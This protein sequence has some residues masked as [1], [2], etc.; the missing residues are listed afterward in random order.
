MLPVGVVMATIRYFLEPW[1]REEIR[2]RAVAV[3]RSGPAGTSGAV[4]LHYIQYAAL[5]LATYK[6]SAPAG[7]SGGNPAEAALAFSETGI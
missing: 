4:L 7:Q 1:K 5:Y 6:E 3:Y 2:L